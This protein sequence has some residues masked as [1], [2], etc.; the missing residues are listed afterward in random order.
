MERCEIVAGIDGVGSSIAEPLLDLA[1]DIG[2]LAAGFDFL[3]VDLYELP[4]RIVFGEITPIPTAGTK[5]IEPYE[6]DQYLGS[7]WKQPRPWWL[8]GRCFSRW[9]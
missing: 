9:N 6:F 7:L 1:R 3:R 2:R 5:R 8:P 4:D